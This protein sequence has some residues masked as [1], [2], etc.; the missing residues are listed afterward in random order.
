[1]S[2]L[3]SSACLLP[4]K[5]FEPSPSPIFLHFPIF[6]PLSLFFLL[7]LLL[8]PPSQSSS[9]LIYHAFFNFFTPSSDV[10]ARLIYP[11]LWLT[12]FMIILK[13]LI[14]RLLL[15]NCFEGLSQH[16]L[17]LLR[18]SQSTT[19]HSLGRAQHSKAV[20]RIY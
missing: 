10:D 14:R 2:N 15:F 5:E 8:H 17:K 16:I 19:C 1:M 3:P 9:S 12:K 6:Q 20:S 7:F 18:R 4:P 11:D 13:P